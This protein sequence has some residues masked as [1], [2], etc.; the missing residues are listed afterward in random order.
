MSHRTGWENDCSPEGP[1][2]IR[3]RNRQLKRLPLNLG[4]ASGPKWTPPGLEPEASSVPWTYSAE[5]SYGPTKPRARFELA[6]YRSASG[7]VT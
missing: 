6:F 3:T 5:L 4:L 2:G 1:G 7:H